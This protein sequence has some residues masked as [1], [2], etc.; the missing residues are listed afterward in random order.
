MQG[1]VKWFNNKK[2]YGFI[3]REGEDDL[4]VHHS[5]IIQDGFRHLSQGDKVSYDIGERDGKKIAVNVKQTED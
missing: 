1:T 4:F 3:I 2:G 5:Q